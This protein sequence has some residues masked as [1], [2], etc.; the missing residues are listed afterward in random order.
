MF[1]AFP[2]WFTKPAEY[3]NLSWKSVKLEGTCVLQRHLFTTSV[4][5]VQVLQNTALTKGL[6]WSQH[7][8]V[9]QNQSGREKNKRFNDSYPEHSPSWIHR[10]PGAN[11]W[12]APPQWVQQ[13]PW[14]HRQNT[15]SWSHFGWKRLLRVPFAYPAL[16]CSNTNKLPIYLYYPGVCHLDK[17]DY[18]LQKVLFHHK[19]PVNG[20][21]GSESQHHVATFTH[22]STGGLAGKKEPR[23]TL[24]NPWLEVPDF[25]RELPKESH[26]HWSSR[27]W[28]CEVS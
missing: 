5:W 11:K 9:S 13:S 25:P 28:D 2:H 17:T 26:V 4:T 1:P 3:E 16:S 20:T 12:H 7:F 6:G 22:S 10:D 14:S 15:E 23:E 27:C 24:P 19:N 21:S 8:V 18:Y